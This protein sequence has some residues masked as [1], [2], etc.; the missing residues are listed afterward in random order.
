MVKQDRYTLDTYTVSFVLTFEILVV[1]YRQVYF[2]TL[3]RTYFFACKHVI[4][5][6]LDPKGFNYTAKFYPLF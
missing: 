2:F 1:R 4:K 6:I 3:F 5:I